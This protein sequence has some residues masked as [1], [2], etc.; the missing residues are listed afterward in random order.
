MIYYVSPSLSPSMLFFYHESLIFIIYVLTA[1]CDL[2]D[3]NSPTRDQIHTLWLEVSLNHWT[4]REVPLWLQMYSFVVSSSNYMALSRWVQNT[5]TA[6]G[7]G[8]SWGHERLLDSGIWR[9]GP[10]Q[11]WD[12]LFGI[13]LPAMACL[14][15]FF[16]FNCPGYSWPCVPPYTL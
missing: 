14:C 7:R 4:T 13:L 15:I 9:P 10:F 3:L 2:W 12:C 8:Q 16:T 5:E 11:S 1:L 6:V